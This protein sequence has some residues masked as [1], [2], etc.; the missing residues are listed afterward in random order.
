[1]NID[2]SSNFFLLHHGLR[3]GLCLSAGMVSRACLLGSFCRSLLCLFSAISSLLSPSLSLSDARSRAAAED[4]SV[5]NKRTQRHFELKTSDDSHTG[6]TR[7][8]CTSHA[9]QR[10]GETEASCGARALSC[11][12]KTPKEKKGEKREKSL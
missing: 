9:V 1:M 4:P 8:A 3:S 10:R 12:Q 6:E 2:F 5:Y 7:V 11:H